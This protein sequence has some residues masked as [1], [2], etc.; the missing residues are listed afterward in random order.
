M[1]PAHGCCWRAETLGEELKDQENHCEKAPPRGMGSVGW[2]LGTPRAGCSSDF[3]TDAAAPSW[4]ALRDSQHLAMKEFLL[5]KTPQT[6][7]G[8]RNNCFLLVGEILLAR[9]K[10]KDHGCGV[11]F[12]LYLRLAPFG[13]D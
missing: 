10:R 13:R 11:L 12:L 8:I 4:M 6:S 9:W 5:T 3:E 2:D 7:L 1:I